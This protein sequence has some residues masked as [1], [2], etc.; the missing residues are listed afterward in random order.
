M[1]P[2]VP[3]C[4]SKVAVVVRLPSTMEPPPVS[5]AGR[6]TQAKN[7]LM[8][9]MWPTAQTIRAY[10]EAKAGPQDAVAFDEAVRDI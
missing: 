3:L 2:A 10:D 1:A 5:V 8:G 4:I 7:G 6:I 9:G